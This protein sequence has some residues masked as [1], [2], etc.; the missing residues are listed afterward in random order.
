MVG[1][2][3]S[4]ERLGNLRALESRQL[5]L[6]GRC[7]RANA[8]TTT[9]PTTKLLTA[10]QVERWGSTTPRKGATPLPFSVAE[11]TLKIHDAQV[12]RRQWCSA[13]RCAICGRCVLHTSS[14]RSS[15]STRIILIGRASL[16]ATSSADALLN[17]FA[18]AAARARPP[19]PPPPLEAHCLISRRHLRA[20]RKSLAH[21]KQLRM[22]HTPTLSA[23]DRSNRGF[24][25]V[26][27]DKVLQVR[28]QSATLELEQHG[29]HYEWDFVP[30]LGKP[31]DH[32]IER[33]R[34]HRA[35]TTLGTN[36]REPVRRAQ[37]AIETQRRKAGR[38]HR[39]NHRLNH[40]GRT[41]AMGSLRSV[42]RFERGA[43]SEDTGGDGSTAA[44]RRKTEIQRL[45][46][47][48]DQLKNDL[49]DGHEDEYSRA[50]G[51]PAAGIAGG[52]SGS[53]EISSGEEDEVESAYTMFLGGG[54]DGGVGDTIFDME[55]GGHNIGVDI[56]SAP[57]D[58]LL[59]GP[60][61]EAMGDLMAVRGGGG[62]FDFASLPKLG[63]GGGGAFDADDEPLPSLSPR[64][65]DGRT[66]G[67]N[68][69]S[70]PERARRPAAAATATIDGGA[71]EG[72][73]PGKGVERRRRDSSGRV[74][75]SQLG[76]RRST[77][78]A[79]GGGSRCSSSKGRPA[80]QGPAAC[81]RSRE[82]P[83]WN[84]SSRPSSRE[85]VAAAR[86]SRGGSRGD[87]C[88]GQGSREVASREPSGLT[89]TARG[90]SSGAQRSAQISSA[91]RSEIEKESL[92]PASSEL[93]GGGSALSLEEVAD[94][95][96]QQPQPQPQPQ[97]QQS[98]PR[99]QSR[100]PPS[101]EAGAEGLSGHSVAKFYG[102]TARASFFELYKAERDAVS[103]EGVAAPLVDSAR[104][105]YL[106][107]CERSKLNP[108]P[109]LVKEFS[110]E[111]QRSAQDSGEG[112]GGGGTHAMQHVDLSAYALGDRLTCAYA[113]GFVRMVTQRSAQPNPVDV[114]SLSFANNALT[115]VGCSAVARCVGVAA[116]LMQLDLSGNRLGVDGTAS[117]AA[118]LREHRSIATL[119]LSKVQLG[120]R[121]A[122]TLLE[123]ISVH[124]TLTE[125][126]LSSNGLGEGGSGFGRSV[127]EYLEANEVL[128]RLELSWNNIRLANAEQLADGL[129]TNS[130]LLE[131]G[132]AWN[133]FGDRGGCAL[134]RALRF[135]STLKEL[136]LTHNSIGE[137]AT[138]VLA[139]A[140]AAENKA[141]RSCQLDENPVG[142]RGGRAVIRALTTLAFLGRD[143]EIDVRGCNFELH[144]PSRSP[145]LSPNRVEGFDR[146]EPGGV[147]R[148]DLSKPLERMV[149]NELVDLAWVEE[150]ENWKD[151]TLDGAPF[152]LPEPPPGET[153]TR[154]DYKL[155]EEGVLQ[156]TYLSTKRTPKMSDVMSK[157]TFTALLRLTKTF[158]A[159]SRRPVLEVTLAPG[160]HEQSQLRAHFGGV[161]AKGRLST[162]ELVHFVDG[163][164]YVPAPHVE[165]THAFVHFRDSDSAER[166]MEDGTMFVAPT[167]GEN[168]ALEVKWASEESVNE[169]KMV[170][171]LR[172]SAAE[173]FYTCEQVS[174]ILDMFDDIDWRVEIIAFLM[175]RT[176]DLVNWNRQVMDYMG[177]DEFKL[178]EA[179]LGLLFYFT[180]SNPSGRYQ[181]QLHNPL[182]RTIIN[183]LVE[184]SIDERK[185]RRPARTEDADLAWKGGMLRNTSQK[186]DWDNWR[187]E[188]I[189]RMDGDGLSDYDFDERRPW[190]LP[191]F[192]LLE[193]DYV[194]TNV[195]HRYVNTPPM[196]DALFA[197]LLADLR[198]VAASI[199]VLPAG[200][201][202]PP[203]PTKAPF[204][205]S[206]VTMV[207][208]AA[209]SAAARA[210]EGEGE[211]GT[212]RNHPKQA[213]R[214]PWEV[215]CM[216]QRAVINVGSLELDSGEWS[217][218]GLLQHEAEAQRDELICGRQLRMLRRSTMELY[219]SD[220]QARAVLGV[221]PRA[222]HVETLV[223][224]FSRITDIENHRQYELLVHEEERQP[225]PGYDDMS[226]RE[227]KVAE[228]VEQTALEVDYQKYVDRIGIANIFNPFHTDV[229]RNLPRDGF[230]HAFVL[231][232]TPCTF[233]HTHTTQWNTP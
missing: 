176:V 11:P 93:G 226:S 51:L 195:N 62:G 33:D 90:E 88:G 160:M 156:V 207:M 5:D 42:V 140:I 76:M 149:A 189:D 24:M 30:K 48:I 22:V 105:L 3:E 125:L 117:L 6:Q 67:P 8:R 86:E 121:C 194:S 224:L 18:A 215:P 79:D 12:S 56:V 2:I 114:A 92:R 183:K 132:L 174:E 49:A 82:Q 13:D 196:P 38:K 50:A 205:R 28:A 74:V 123:Q 87:S 32:Q 172:I 15:R 232:C 71:T 68:L 193:F 59:V 98:V 116:G 136:D 151:E 107:K 225:I 127:A 34:L 171:L 35:A 10:M 63:D 150:G 23:L 57:F 89:A 203:P 164:G 200:S 168:V 52:S 188:R 4:Q 218:D 113:K 208:M 73:L 152:E 70:T 214:Q 44:A 97:P 161:V 84:S 177:A 134:G 197:K 178:V 72:P 58:E 223:I 75:V 47:E 155:P 133:S 141:L 128:L 182:E 9:S 198:R 102:A 54:G 211:G 192:G 26:Q 19:P 66:R 143:T 31:A 229:R 159:D 14:P 163:L 227:R 170:Q 69:R 53:S 29:I 45:Q 228:A 77:D 231:A 119:T 166:A 210:A 138:M 122:R 179:K 36:R 139:D 80:S 202:P 103:S 104:R 1:I 213:D 130:S 20:R 37:T 112:E 175:P 154:D 137:K 173:A 110:K 64:L 118:T 191:P 46:G 212:A 99:Q 95:L 81:S 41:A 39:V 220:A 78:P 126:D 169:E 120:D 55:R 230:L 142:P 96:R 135:N 181:L 108:W 106:E 186:G 184:I 199:V 162:V 21:R 85:S 124:P 7:R 17:F 101:E 146:A 100:R 201:E 157:A 185:A 217:A 60:R 16:A 43:D 209:A 165:A 27:R 94:A 153:W 148:C 167:S 206:S 187:N 129:V 111:H 216:F 65:S 144:D 158:A 219:Y 25:Q 115:A 61:G 190:N 221:V 40:G 145:Q 83:P 233:T 91:Q 204:R 131:L 147:W 109:L 180:P 222:A